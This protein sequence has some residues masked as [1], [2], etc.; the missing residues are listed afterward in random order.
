MRAPS[1]SPSRGASAMRHDDNV[2]TF[3]SVS[4]SSAVLETGGVATGLLGGVLLFGKVHASC[5]CCSP[6]H[7]FNCH[8]QP[9][10]TV[11]N[12]TRSK[13]GFAAARSRTCAA[14]SAV[15]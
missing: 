6:L 1:A 9:A 12:T 2:H 10:P 15:G 11:W 13:F 3:R 4:R 14:L 5:G 7:A 8:G